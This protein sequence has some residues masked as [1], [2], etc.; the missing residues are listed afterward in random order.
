VR[1]L[2]AHRV[3]IKPNQDVI[4]L[5]VFT[6]AGRADVRCI[7]VSAHV[8]GLPRTASRWSRSSSAQL[9]RMAS[10]A[11]VFVTLLAG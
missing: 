11:A 1:T 2:P 10:A 9:F 5:T 8:F 7:S 6:L 4:P 3:W